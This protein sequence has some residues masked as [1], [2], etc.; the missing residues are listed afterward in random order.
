MTLRK[1]ELMVSDTEKN[2][3]YPNTKTNEMEYG[4]M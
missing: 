3:K 1:R 4:E 2:N